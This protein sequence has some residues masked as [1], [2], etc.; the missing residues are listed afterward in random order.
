MLPSHSLAQWYE[1]HL[2]FVISQQDHLSG[3]W[4]EQLFGPEAS[5]GIDRVVQLALSSCRSG[6]GGVWLRLLPIPVLG[7]GMTIGS[8]TSAW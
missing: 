5:A 3:S 2:G 7:A 1:Q 6:V 8:S 4:L